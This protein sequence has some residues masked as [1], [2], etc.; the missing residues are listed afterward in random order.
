VS[1]PR[2][3]GALLDVRKRDEGSAKVALA[4][5]IEATARARTTVAA[6]L[7]ALAARQLE[8]KRSCDKEAARHS[9]SAEERLAF[10]HWDARL[11]AGVTRALAAVQRAEAALRA[12]ESEE[13]AARDALADA[14]RGREALERHLERREGSEKR[15]AER[16]KERHS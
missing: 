14:Y 11:A 15:E 9:A 3:L 10:R 13:G 12:R 1:T 5:A 16:R 4:E 8:R 6:A 2:Q 7:D